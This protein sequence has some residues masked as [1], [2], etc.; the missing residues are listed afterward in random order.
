MI[1]KNMQQFEFKSKLKDIKRRKKKN[2]NIIRKI[3]FTK[4][5]S[6]MDQIEEES[7][8]EFIDIKFGP[9]YF[10]VNG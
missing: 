6:E 5:Y 8:D 10:K 9:T 7:G 3:D 2:E 1:N 4:K